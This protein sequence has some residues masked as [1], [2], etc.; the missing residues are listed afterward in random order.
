VGGG[1]AERTVQMSYFLAQEGIDC[2]ILCTDL[3]LSDETKLYLKDVKIAA[4]PCLIKR[5]YIPMP[6][7]FRINTLVKKA[8]LVHIMNHWT[9]LNVWVYLLVRWHKRPYV[10]CPAGAL[11]LFG[12]SQTLK[13]L[14]NWIIGKNIIRNADACIA[15][16]K[17]EIPQFKS[18]GVEEQKVVVI[19]N[20]IRCDYPPSEAGAANFRKKFNLTATPFILFLG[21]LNLIKGPDLLLNAFCKIKNDF[22]SFHLVI[23]GPDEGLLGEMQAMAG[24]EKILERVHFI[25]PIRGEEKRHAYEA[26]DLLVIP[27]RQEAM[28][29]V[30]LEAG[31]FGTPVLFS[32]QC[33]LGELASLN[34]G[35]EVSVSVEEIQSGLKLLLGNKELRQTLGR[36]LR[37]HILQTYDWKIVVKQYLKLYQ[38]LVRR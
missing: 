3:A 10:V 30:V 34:C 16:T 11:P 19:P 15:V 23:A 9:I 8:D 2:S 12:R 27:S 18:Y 6:D 20:G 25:G 7:F 37:A 24:Q 1:T 35:H 26:A 4:L 14:F 32:D 13:K 5:F 33:G 28:S 21:R 17:D 36:N 22:P 38:K 29:I 31:I